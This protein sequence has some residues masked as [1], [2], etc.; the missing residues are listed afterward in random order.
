MKRRKKLRFRLHRP[1]PGLALNRL[2]ESRGHRHAEV[3]LEQQG[4][5]PLQGTDVGAA[6]RQDADVAE[7]DVLYSLPE[8]LLRLE[9]GH[10]PE[11]ELG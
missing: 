9:E 1:A 10:V 11:S 3:R 4:L 6:A 2:D 5:E 7:G 8:T